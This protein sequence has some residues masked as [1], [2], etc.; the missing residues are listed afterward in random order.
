MHIQV[1]F[2]CLPNFAFST[3]SPSPGSSTEPGF[4]LELGGWRCRKSFNAPGC[5]VST[6][7]NIKNRFP[8]V[9]IRK[10]FAGHELSTD[11]RFTK[12]FL[13]S[14]CS[15]TLTIRIVSSTL[16]DHAQPKVTNHSLSFLPTNSYPETNRTCIEKVGSFTV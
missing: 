4:T 8:Y 13:R 11:G 3:L 7:V 10:V 6:G 9:F 15:L 14:A 2:I 12:S 5:L 16:Y 1:E